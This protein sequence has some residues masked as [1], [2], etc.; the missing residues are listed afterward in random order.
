MSHL[1]VLCIGEV[2]NKLCGKVIVPVCD[3]KTGI[4]FT[5][6]DN[7]QGQIIILLCKLSLSVLPC[8][9]HL[10]QQPYLYLLFLKRRNV[11]A[12]SYSCFSIKFIYYK[13]PPH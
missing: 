9:K 3:Y 11:C 12:R 1:S 10:K 6:C 13:L 5:C 8:L 2:H 7:L 4:T